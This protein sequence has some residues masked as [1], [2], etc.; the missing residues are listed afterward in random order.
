[1]QLHVLELSKHMTLAF[2]SQLDQSNL[3]LV[4]D[5]FHREIMEGG[6]AGIKSP[7]PALGPAR[8]NQAEFSPRLTS[9]ASLHPSHSSRVLGSLW[10]SFRFL[11]LG[12]LQPVVILVLIL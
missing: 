12:S 11:L 5:W 3:Q 9:S 10:E 1:M 7:L 8:S 4:D 2:S 6:S